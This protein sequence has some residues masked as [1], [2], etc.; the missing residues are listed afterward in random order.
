MRCSW[1]TIEEK[2]IC[3]FLKLKYFVVFLLYNKYTKLIKK[4]SSKWKR[5]NHQQN[6]RGHVLNW[7]KIDSTRAQYA[8]A[9]FNN[10]W[11]TRNEA[12][13]CRL[14][15]GFYNQS[16]LDNYR[17]PFK[18]ELTW[19]KYLDTIAVITR[20]NFLEDN[21]GHIFCNKI[22]QLPNILLRRCTIGYF[23]CWQNHLSEM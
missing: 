5:K 21:H 13:V 19:H 3:R 22:Q 16:L 7:K 6:W 17:E 12:S 1:I 4:N 18:H 8:H 15:R 2:R 9:R 11:T 14:A 20:L 10:A 23:T